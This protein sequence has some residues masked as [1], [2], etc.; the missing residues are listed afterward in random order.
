MAYDG[1]F[2]MLTEGNDELR[3]LKIHSKLWSE[4]QKNSVA[5]FK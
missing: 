5:A 2:W 3:Y 4:N 1:F